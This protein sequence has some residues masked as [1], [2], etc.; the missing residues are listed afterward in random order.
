MFIM[1]ELRRS[2]RIKTLKEA[3][4]VAATV[5]GVSAASSSKII[6]SATSATFSTSTG[7]SQG[8]LKKV[9]NEIPKKNTRTP[10]LK[11]KSEDGL[12]ATEKQLGKTKNVKSA[13]STTT[14]S[15]N[16]NKRQSSKK[17]E[18]LIFIQDIDHEY[19]QSQIPNNIA[20]IDPLKLKEGTI[21]G[22]SHL[23]KIDPVIPS[24]LD[25]EWMAELF[26]PFLLKDEEKTINQNKN[27][28]TNVTTNTNNDNGNG[29]EKFLKYYQHIANGVLAQQISGAAARSII[30]KFKLLYQDIDKDTV[31]ETIPDF[32][33]L[34]KKYL[35]QAEMSNNTLQEVSNGD[36]ENKS[37]S[38]SQNQSQNQEESQKDK[39]KSKDK[40]AKKN[41]DYFVL[42]EKLKYPLPKQVANTKIEI[43]RSAGLSER[44]AEYIIGISKAFS[45]PEKKN[46]EESIEEKNISKSDST[47]ND[48]DDNNNNGNDEATQR[49]LEI[50]STNETNESSNKKKK[51]SRTKTKTKTKTPKEPI[52]LTLDLFETGTDDEIIDALVSLKGI[53]PWSAEM[54]LLFGLQRFNVFSCGDLGIQRGASVYLKQRP[55]IVKEMNEDFIK[56]KKEKEENENNND[57]DLK[58]KLAKKSKSSIAINNNNSK[59][60]WKAPKNHELEWLASKFSPYKSLLM[61]VLWKLGGMDLSVFQK[62]DNENDDGNNNNNKK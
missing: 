15:S 31:P 24:M 26:R 38:Q 23:L 48:D 4:T 61:M 22:V 59:T 3:A 52:P 10:R 40:P 35:E 13:K 46:S 32:D 57:D 45:T 47:P 16:N 14:S 28:N 43:L 17:E 53:G 18:T 42:D 60:S 58:P 29:N 30:R 51:A 21:E 20:A 62:K 50:E 34:T 54:F 19:H 7:T 39:K 8:T 37:E 33:E 56:Q 41:I 2:A 12:L 55:D 25:K 36:D 6:P 49:D 9:P 11:R 1:S 5:S 44:K 27:E